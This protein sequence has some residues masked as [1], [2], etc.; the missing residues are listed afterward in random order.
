MKRTSRRWK[1]SWMLVVC[2]VAGLYSSG[3]SAYA[4]AGA[5]SEIPKIIEKVS[6][7]VVAIIGKPTDGKQSDND[8]FNLA[9][10]TGVIVK[11]NGVILTNAHVVKQ[12]KN[13][14]VVT[15]DGKTY[16]GKTT[17]YDEESDLALIHIDA[18]SLPAATFAAPND[19]K[20]GETVMAIGTPISFALRNSVTVGIISGLDRSLES[21][22]QLLQTDAAI[23]PGNSGGA[24]VN[25][26]GK[27]VGINSQ[28]YID[29]MVESLGFAIPVNTV[30]YV[31]EHFEKYGKVMRPYMGLELEESWEAVVGLP[32]KESL[33]VAYVDPDS[34]A[35]KSGI[36]QGD[37]IVSF[38]QTSVETI[39]EYNEIMKKYLPKDTLKITLKSD[40]KTVTRSVVLEEDPSSSKQWQQD[41]EGAY[42]DDDQGKTR[43]GDS[44]LGWSMK[45]PGGLIKANQSDDGNRVTFADSKG[46]FAITISVEEKQN[47]ELSVMGLLRKLTR[48]S[49]DMLLEKRY[50]D[51]EPVPY[52]KVVGKS[53]E[54]TYYQARAYLKGDKIYY[55]GLIV[56]SAEN[57]KNKV[58]HNAYMDLLESFSLSF[59]AKDDALKDISVFKEGDTTF[60]NEYGL[61]FD[62]PSGWESDEYSGELY[63]SNPDAAQDVSVQVT[64]ASSGETL[65]DWTAREERQFTNK[66]AADYME[67]SDRKEL[68]ADGVPVKE[69]RYSWRMGGDSWNSSVMLYF[70]KDKYK[71]AV[72]IQFDKGDKEEEAAKLIDGIVKSMKVSK[73]KMNTSLGF[74]QD[75]DD[76]I[77]PNK[78]LAYTNEKFKYSIRIP[79]GWSNLSSFMKESP[80]M[81]FNFT[82]GSLS[83]EA[84]DKS[85]LED[86]MKK[87]EQG[88][89]KSNDN[90]NEYKYEISD[91]STF[92]EGGKKI[93]IRYNLKKAPYEQTEYVFRSNNVTYTITLKMNDAVRTQENV[94]RADAA[95]KSFQIKQ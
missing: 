68:S 35:A 85:N 14:V 65:A 74:I 89:K 83:V 55:I 50:V 87:L 36:K 19:I 69:I 34:P 21:P 15:S 4:A 26:Q 60:T 59:D 20:V 58:K 84:D 49:D 86:V 3:L 8:R 10:G 91:D 95:V 40:G 76:L 53:S 54:D 7:S 45:Y 5:D 12:M 44:H 39:V 80:R 17:H 94:S 62:L 73:D 11:S 64:S 30:Q 52:A 46:E 13:I 67:I 61:S 31:L 47:E 66:Y 48:N 56:E 88:H 9:H 32:A 78:T 90:D 63:Y 33:K 41:S 42:I 2:L 38:D 25:M 1:L 43:I 51:T 81:N 23:N 57:Y 16:P 28:K 92:A 27:V 79:E 71:Y 93:A 6:P 24:L 75:E 70:I 29:Y 77:D 72:S 82:G 22:Y 37:T 18:Y